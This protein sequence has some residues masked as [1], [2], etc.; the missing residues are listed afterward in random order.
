MVPGTGLKAGGPASGAKSGGG[1]GGGGGGGKGKKKSS[2]AAR[3][4]QAAA[5]PAKKLTKFQARRKP[6]HLAG[7]PSPPV[8]IACGGWHTVVRCE[9]HQV[10]AFGDN[11]KGQCGI[12]DGGKTELLFR[13]RRA[14]GKLAHERAVSWVAAG[15]QCSAAVA[16]ATLYTWGRADSGELGLGAVQ[17][18]DDISRPCTCL[19]CYGMTGVKPDVV[20]CGVAHMAAIAG[21]PTRDRFGKRTGKTPIALSWGAA[22]AGRLGTTAGEAKPG[23]KCGSPERVPGLTRDVLKSA[24]ELVACGREH[25][26]FVT[27]F[28]AVWG[29]GANN[30]GQLGQGDENP[31]TRY[32]PV[33]VKKF[34]QNPVTSLAVGLS[35]NVA[36][37]SMGTSYTWGGNDVGQLGLGDDDDRDAPVMVRGELAF[38]RTK[39]VAAGDKHTLFVT[40]KGRLFVVGEGGS[41]QLGI[42][43]PDLTPVAVPR[44]T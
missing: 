6:A 22:T 7:W 36:R 43:Y 28:G 42:D 26:M 1:G 33:P 29:F 11:T 15:Q 37:I 21:E 40:D 5:A 17:A 19:P 34:L 3:R 10:L 25:T 44:N 8:Q 31:A 30:R 32:S 38:L 41:G 16:G 12:G 20:A 24:I 14:Q 4:Q 35:H 27:A 13:A 23:S 2:F 18:D 39:E 9:G